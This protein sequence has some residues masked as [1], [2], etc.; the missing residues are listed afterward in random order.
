LTQA[1][2]GQNCSLDLTEIGRERKVSRELRND[3]PGG[4]VTIGNCKE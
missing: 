2:G 3:D 1:P 4:R